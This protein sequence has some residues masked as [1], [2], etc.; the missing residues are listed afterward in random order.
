M[1]SQASIVILIVMA[2]ISF[3]SIYGIISGSL[4]QKIENEISLVH[5]S[6]II[7]SI[8]NF[9]M[10][11]IGAKVACNYSAFQGI[12]HVGINGGY[13]EVPSNLNFNSYSIWRNYSKTFF[14]TLYHYNI[15][16]KTQKI[17]KE[18]ADQIKSE[19]EVKNLVLKLKGME[20]ENDRFNFSLEVNNLLFCKEGC[21]NELGF[22]F[23]S[24][25]LTKFKE[26]MEHANET[27]LNKDFLNESLKNAYKNLP[28]N[29]T[30]IEIGNI[31][32]NKIKPLEYY[33]ENCSE[34]EFGINCENKEIEECI[35]ETLLLVN[36]SFIE[37][38][39]G[40]KIEENDF[41]AR[42][43]PLKSIINF[44]YEVKYS[45]REDSKE[46]GCKR[47]KIVLK[48]KWSKPPSNVIGCVDTDNGKDYFT[49]GYC[50]NETDSFVDV[51]IDEENY[52]EYYCEN[53]LCK[54]EKVNCNDVCLSLGYDKGFVSN[55]GGGC[56]C[57]I[58]EDWYDVLK[59]TKYVY[60]YPGAMAALVEYQDIY[61]Y[62]VYNYRWR[63]TNYFNTTIDFVSI[64]GSKKVI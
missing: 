3:A 40:V 55:M 4:I 15:T 12:Y 63:Q 61:K 45:S 1:K 7:S 11:K 31:C 5:A 20:E 33:I 54:Y 34:Y 59:N 32:E 43:K 62:P 47:W 22:A 19:K 17:M 46:C 36:Q 53:N 13:E 26:M 51:R 6:R 38:I 58:C 42:M 56:V 9:E 24:T 48:P 30:L 10:I 23:N 25:I 57:E 14:P 27:F 28:K 29:C 18:Y 8:N 16:N 2:A 49:I 50:E 52:K 60:K 21:L 37:F 41:S 35:N 64:T 39:K 44:E